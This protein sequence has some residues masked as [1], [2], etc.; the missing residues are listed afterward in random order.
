MIEAAHLLGMD[1]IGQRIRGSAKP[2]QWF[3]LHSFSLEPA[4]TVRRQL[5]KASLD[6]GEIVLSDWLVSPELEQSEL[7][8]ALGRHSGDA[9]AERGFPNEYRTALSEK[10]QWDEHYR[11]SILFVLLRGRSRQEE[12]PGTLDARNQ[13]NL[14]WQK[15]WRSMLLKPTLER[16]NGQYGYRIA[17]LLGCE[18]VDDPE[19]RVARLV[20]DGILALESRI[21]SFLRRAR[22]DDLLFCEIGA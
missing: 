20:F 15:R 13:R 4:E 22:L 14:D 17:N 12:N 2:S 7:K 6:F 8:D 1:Q 11:L 9:L 18:W 19:T 10:S 16:G 21:G 3:T 5:A